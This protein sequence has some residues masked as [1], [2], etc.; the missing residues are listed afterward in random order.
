LTKAQSDPSEREKVDSIIDELCVQAYIGYENPLTIGLIV[1]A[2]SKL[3]I[4]TSFA[5]NPKIEKVLDDL[6]DSRHIN[7]QQRCL[8]YQALKEVYTQLP[9]HGTTIFNNTPTNEEQCMA[10]GMD[11]SLGFLNDFVQAEVNNGKALYD[12]TKAMT[13][14]SIGNALPVASN[15]NFRAYQ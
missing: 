14:E 13:T 4:A 10:E 15:L 2:L 6:I 12:T 5:S 1:Q 11:L 7:V 9:E 3:H 8:E